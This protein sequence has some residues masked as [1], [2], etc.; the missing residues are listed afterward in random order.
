MEIIEHGKTYKIFTCTCC[1]CVFAACEKDVYWSE[2]LECRCV[3]CPE[4]EKETE[5][6]GIM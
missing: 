6:K 5:V 1:G 3:K 2:Y 4:Y